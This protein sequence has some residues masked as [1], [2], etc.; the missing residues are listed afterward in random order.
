[1]ILEKK[2]V[3]LEGQKQDQDEIQ[4]KN[5]L[6]EQENAELRAQ[7]KCTND[8]LESMLYSVS[9][10]ARA[11]LRAIDGYSRIL[12]Q[13]YAS[14]LDEEGLRLLNIVRS[15]T[16]KMD[17]IIFDLL[18][19]S[20][21][22]RSELV[23]DRID[24]RIMVDSVFKEL[25]TPEI[26]DKFSF[27]VKELPETVG[28]PVLIRQAWISLFANSIKFSRSKEQPVIVVSGCEDENMC[29]YTITDNG[30]GF[31]P[32]YKEELFDLFK[33]LHNTGEFEGNGVGLTIV[34][35][36]IRRHGGQIWGDGQP[37]AGSVFSFTLPKKNLEK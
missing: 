26:R 20:R 36:I 12:E 8:E 18:S 5:L 4:Q 25:A 11:P 10:D 3:K 33:R 29:T 1:V 21:V 9:H 27:T 34:Q 2:E 24:M 30:V 6:L 28:D 14:V 31:N 13:D 15:S 16:K 35:R 32:K 7:L 37:D 17:G 22:G 19:L 23:Y